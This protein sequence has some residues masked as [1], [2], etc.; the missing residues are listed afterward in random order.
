MVPRRGT[1]KGYALKSS[2]LKACKGFALDQGVRVKI[3]DF[4]SMQGLRP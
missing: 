1:I 4:K 3:F 2:I